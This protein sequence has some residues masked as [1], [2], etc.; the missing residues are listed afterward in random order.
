VGMDG[1]GWVG[2]AG[3]EET[4]VAVVMCATTSEQEGPASCLVP[5]PAMAKVRVRIGE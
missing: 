4:A 2:A 5:S 1:G 3:R